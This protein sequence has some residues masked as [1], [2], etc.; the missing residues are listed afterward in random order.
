LETISG[1]NVPWLITT[2][3]PLRAFSAIGQS[4]KNTLSVFSLIESRARI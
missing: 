3:V 2:I 1:R 4:V